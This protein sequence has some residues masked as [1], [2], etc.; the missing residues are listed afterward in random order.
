MMH[1]IYQRSNN[2]KDKMFRIDRGN[3]EDDRD[4]IFPKWDW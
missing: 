3:R 4:D 1:R 2:V